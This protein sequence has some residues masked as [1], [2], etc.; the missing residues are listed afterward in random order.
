MFRS[1]PEREGYLRLS[2]SSKFRRGD[3]DFTVG[4]MS[5]RSADGSAGRNLPKPWRRVVEYG[6]G[7][8]SAQEPLSEPRCIRTPSPK[9]SAT[10]LVALI[11]SR[12][13][14]QN[15]L[16]AA[17]AVQSASRRRIFQA[18]NAWCGKFCFEHGLLLAR[19]A[20]SVHGRRDLQITDGSI[21][22]RPTTF[23]LR[24]GCL[25]GDGVASKL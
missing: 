22:G 14:Y 4:A 1:F 12:Q 15:L 20:G 7:L 17:I 10:I 16:P 23:R 8:M 5:A 11:G 3:S 25:F 9:A 18:D 24:F 19:K 21:Q 2:T 6:C 13:H